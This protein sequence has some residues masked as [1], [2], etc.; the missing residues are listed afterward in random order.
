MKLFTATTFTWEQLGLLKWGVL[1]IGI[2]IGAE[3]PDAFAPYV[4]AFV[5]IGLLFCIPPALA[6]LREH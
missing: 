2:A 1:F 6:W 5:I 3:W 4:L